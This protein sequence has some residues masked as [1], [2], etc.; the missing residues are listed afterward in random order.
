MRKVL[1]TAA[2]LLALGACRAESEDESQNTPPRNTTNRQAP[3]AQERNARAMNP[4][5]PIQ[6][7]IPSSTIGGAAPPEIQIELTEYAIRIPPQIPAGHQTLTVVNSGKERHSL[8]LEADGHQ[9]KLPEPMARGDRG[10]LNLELTPGTYTVWC[11]V[12]GHRG[13]G[14][15]TTVVVK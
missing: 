12:D 2:L 11:P 9:Y 7:E 6:K 4:P 1:I 13:K 10:S 8:I 14:M 3:N 5:A 15:S